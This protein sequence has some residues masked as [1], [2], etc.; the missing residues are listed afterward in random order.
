MC[1]S[2]ASRQLPVLPSA[3]SELCMICLKFRK[4]VR[5]QKESALVGGSMMVPAACGSTSQ[6]QVSMQPAWHAG[7][8]TVYHQVCCHDHRR[9]GLIS[10]QIVDSDGV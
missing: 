1:S 7:H 8:A 4:G 3:A 10:M 9:H 2:V 6:D 5:E